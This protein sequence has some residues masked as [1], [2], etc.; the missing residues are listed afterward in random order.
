MTRQC[1]DHNMPEGWTED[2]PDERDDVEEDDVDGGGK[3]DE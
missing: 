1:L 3:V 2:V